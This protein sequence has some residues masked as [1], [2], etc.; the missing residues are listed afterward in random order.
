MKKTLL[1]ATLLFA[2]FQME[3]QNVLESLN[4]ENFTLGNADGQNGYTIFNGVAADYQILNDA[5]RLKYLQISGS[6]G[7]TATTASRY[8]FP[9]ASTLGSSWSGRTAGNNI[10]KGEFD[11]FTGTSTVITAGRAGSYVF[12]STGNGVIGITWNANTK[13]LNGYLGLTLISTGAEGGYN[14]SFTGTPVLA[15]NAWYKVGYE[16]DY[17]TGN[18]KFIFP[19]GS[20]YTWDNTSNATVSVI[21]NNNPDEQDFFV[22]TN[23]S[24]AR[25]YGFDNYK[26]SATNASL[27]ATSDAVKGEIS[28]ISVY[29][30]PTTDVLNISNTKKV[31]NYKVF[32]ASG[33]V[34]LN[35][36][37]IDLSVNVS[38]LTKGSY[39][40]QFETIENGLETRKFIKK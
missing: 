39:V 32:D 11:I 21:P 33:K 14:L 15:E 4:F 40:I 8:Y 1:I 30:N 16:Y 36:R 9:A 37:P 12:N 26:L 28:K 29:P 6:G 38:K 20:A 34:V 10:L 35:G 27:L 24:A 31:L 25:A 3:A 7:T 18:G 23:A 19:N 22:A 17:T 2:G 13:T 5:T